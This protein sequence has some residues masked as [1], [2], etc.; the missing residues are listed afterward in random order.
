MNLPEEIGKRQIIEVIGEHPRIGEI[1][2][3]HGIGC[4]SCSIGTCLVES[5][6]AVHFL[7]D[8]TEAVIEKEIN[9]YLESVVNGN[10]KVCQGGGKPALGYSI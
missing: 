6:V 8:E 5:V 7:G 2:D 1:L 3:R 4:T 10:E 9:A